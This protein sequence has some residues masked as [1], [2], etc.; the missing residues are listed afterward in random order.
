[1]IFFFSFSSVTH[2]ITRKNILLQIYYMYNYV[3]IDLGT[4]TYHNRAKVS[5]NRNILL[6]N[7]KLFS[8]FVS[9]KRIK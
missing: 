1:M 9:D 8:G 3:F 2:H 6:V 7:S 4:H 5:N